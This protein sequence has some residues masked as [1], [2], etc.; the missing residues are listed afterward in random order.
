MKESF[1]MR[2]PVNTWTHFV[3]F[4]AGIAGLIFL[5]VLTR[6]NAL[7]MVAMIIYGASLVVLYGASSLYHWAKT[8]PRKQLLLEKIDHVSIYHLIA[9]TYTPVLVLGLSGA[10]KWGMLVAVWVLAIAGTLL[11]IWFMGMPRYVSTTLYVVM[12]WLALIP[13]PHLIRNLPT[14]A[15]VLMVIGGVFYTLG[16]VIYATK[17][18]DFF[19]RYFGFHEIFHLFVVAGS[20]AH[21]MMILLYLVPMPAI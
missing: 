8:D 6:D 1:K 16:A 3:A 2:E 12:G 18:C 5:T 13:F 4:I 11:K 20:L 19:P 14:G 9:G 15:I 10:W 21:F 7:K 17:R